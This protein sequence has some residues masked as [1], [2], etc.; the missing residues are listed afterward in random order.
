MRDAMKPLE[1]DAPRAQLHR[2]RAQSLAGRMLGNSFDARIPKGYVVLWVPRH[3]L[4]DGLRN[5]L[6]LDLE[7]LYMA[8]CAPSSGDPR[9][10]AWTVTY[11]EAVMATRA[12]KLHPTD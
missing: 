6:P 12:A 1:S 11:G 2:E 7:G 10:R 9:W 4:G 3:K 8:R 5:G